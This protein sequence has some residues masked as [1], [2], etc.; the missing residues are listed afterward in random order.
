MS[1]I[2][3]NVFRSGKGACL[4]VLEVENGQLLARPKKEEEGV[5]AFRFP[6]RDEFLTF[7]GDDGTQVVLKNPEGMTL[8]AQRDALELE[9]EGKGD[10]AFQ[11]RL[12]SEGKKVVNSRRLS[13]L[14]FVGFFLG[15]AMLCGLGLL[16]LNWGVDRTVDQIPISWEEQLGDLVMEGGIGPE[17]EAPEV[18][19]PVRAVL[20]RLVKA[21][22]DQ[23][24][25]LK[26]HVVESEQLNAFAAPGGQIVVYTGLL[27]KT[28]SPDELAGV[29]A[30]ELQHVYNR[31]GLRNMVHSVKWQ[32]VAA[33]I[34]G[35][36]G[37]V[38]QVVLAQAPD[39]LTL[40][41]GRS[42]EEEAD[43]E[44]IELLCRAHIDP[45]GMVEFFKIMKDNELVQVPEFLSSHP[46]TGNRIESLKNYIQE[47]PDCEPDPLQ[48]DWENM[49]KAL[50][51]NPEP[52]GS[53]TS[54]SLKD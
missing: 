10:R 4:C 23:P 1:Q 27:E 18:V 14:A 21:D 49:K 46:D 44:G 29:L 36:V 32:I 33:L 6:L 11:D 34:I 25:N 9:L 3:G 42:L 45:N 51:S 20:D 41:Y 8:Y 54:S 22:P 48:L 52:V 12:K 39:F 31:H 16:I 53:E 43:L 2:L 24:Y 47:H 40:S 13:V 7:G 35:D 19:E 17:V 50:K 26:L 38:Q 5:D 30:H 28:N 37:S 15:C